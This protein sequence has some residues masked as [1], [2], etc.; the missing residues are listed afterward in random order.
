MSFHQR[1][2]KSVIF[3]SVFGVLTAFANTAGSNVDMVLVDKPENPTEDIYIYTL[4]ARES[5]IRAKNR[6]SP[7]A[8]KSTGDVKSLSF[9]A[10]AGNKWEW[11]VDYLH[12]R[13]KS[14]YLEDSKVERLVS[15]DILPNATYFFNDDAYLTVLGGARISYSKV[16]KTD[17]I[18]RGI[19]AKP[20]SR[21]GI[22]GAEIGIGKDLG[23]WNPSI[24]AAVIYENERTR[25]YHFS[26]GEISQKKWVHFIQGQVTGRLDVNLHENFRP[27]IRAGHKSMLRR[28]TSYTIQ[29]WHGWLMGGGINLFHGKKWN[30]SLDY[31]Y[32][33]STSGERESSFMLKL[34]FN[35]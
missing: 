21:V 3:F 22:L 10:E 2:L 32:N 8:G 1:I 26:N 14:Q 20:S 12:T 34:A 7:L 33:K 35:F 4:T 16:T 27:Y 11:G 5:F 25:R 31:D 18:T 6:F 23:I 24:D 30:T 15:H 17:G 19:S 29:S 9:K 28:S 13:K